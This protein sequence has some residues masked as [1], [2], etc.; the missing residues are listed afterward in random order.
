MG[1]YQVGP[2]E[3]DFTIYATDSETDFDQGVSDGVD[4]AFHLGYSIASGAWKNQFSL[5]YNRNDLE[6][7]F[8]GD[9]P[10]ETD[11]NSDRYQLAWLSEYEL[12][13]N[14]TLL[15]GLDVYEEFGTNEGSFSDDRTNVGG[16]V[17]GVYRNGAHSFDA[18]LRIDDDEN[19]GVEPTGQL[20]YGYHFTQNF[21]AIASY[22]RGFRSP[23]FSQLFSPGFGGLFA[24]NPALEPETSDALELSLRFNHGSHRLSLNGF[25]QDIDQLIDFSGENFQAVNIDQAEIL[26]VELDYQWSSS[27]LGGCCQCNPAE[28]GG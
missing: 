2:G 13:P 16:F 19:F 5:N 4:Q 14:L 7:L 20:A 3:V 23:T 28:C 21:Q 18:S 1:D 17:G 27:Q 12:S 25:Y 15:S 6:T 24:G 11:F 26:G 10:F 22:A 9:F 8:T